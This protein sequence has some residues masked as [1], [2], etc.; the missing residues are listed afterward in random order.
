MIQRIQTI[1]IT[2]A[3]AMMALLFLRPMSLLGIE[4]VSEN[5]VESSVLADGNF[6]IDDNSV[7]LVLVALTMAL[8]IISIF[9]FRN[10]MLQIKVN[11]ISI[12][13]IGLIIILS[14]IFFW[15]DY[16]SLAENTHILP[17]FGYGLIILA[18]TFILL[19][20]RYIRKD[21]NL[22][23]SSDRLR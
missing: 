17:H 13:L 7:V 3:V 16:Q 20:I 2:L 18:I 15:Q 9:L 6:S 8:L 19:A 4:P 23:R 21:E 22:V 14:I 11:W 1:F 5:V 12:F 10:R